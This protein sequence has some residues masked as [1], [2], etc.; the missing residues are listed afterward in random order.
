[1]PEKISDTVYHG[2]VV[3]VDLQ[4]F[5]LGSVTS[6]DLANVDLS[7]KGFDGGFTDGRYAY[8]VPHQISVME[9][10][11]KLARVDLTN[12]STSGVE[13]LDLAAQDSNL[14]GFYGGFT[15]GRY[16]YL[17]PY[18]DGASSSGKIARIQFFSGVG[19]P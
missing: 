9:Y 2:K 5:S 8:L 7:L 15:D 16:G 13:W 3:R 10:S 11:G 17:V 1:M 6:L 18:F 4:N 12:F 19:A 14:K